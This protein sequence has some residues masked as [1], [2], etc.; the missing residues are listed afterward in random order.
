MKTNLLQPSPPYDSVAR[1]GGP[2]DRFVAS[3]LASS[4]DRK[5]AAGQLPR[6]SAALAIRAQQIVSP[7]ARRELIRNWIHVLNLARRSP[8]PI[9]SRGPLCRGAVA[10]AEREVREMICVLAGGLPIAPRGAALARWLL[11]DGTGPLHNLGCPLD[12][13]TAVR[14]ATRQMD[15]FP[16]SQP[17]GADPDVAACCR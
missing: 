5:L 17:G 6:S 1:P 2:W 16:D 12:L 14:E 11:I 7:T 8:V 9:S 10:A 13:S 4:L 15:S 3:M